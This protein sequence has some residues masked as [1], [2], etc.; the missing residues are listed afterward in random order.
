MPIPILQFQRDFVRDYLGPVMRSDHP[1]V[2]LMV[3]DHNKYECCVLFNND[4][5]RFNFSTPDAHLDNMLPWVETIFGGH[6]ALNTEC[7]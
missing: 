6:N 7:A 3:W 5:S 4:A 2:K 1:D